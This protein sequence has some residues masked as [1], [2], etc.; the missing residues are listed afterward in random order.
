MG[1]P[2]E[3]NASIGAA[4][5]ALLASAEGE[6]MDF[7]SWNGVSDLLMMVGAR[8]GKEA[9]VDLVANTDTN[10]LLGSGAHRV[11][12]RVWEVRSR[13][14]DGEP[15]GVERG[16]DSSY[17]CDLSILT[18]IPGGLFVDAAEVTRFEEDLPQKSWIFGVP[19]IEGPSSTSFRAVAHTTGGWVLRSS[20]ENET[21]PSQVMSVSLPV[22][23]RYPVIVN[24]GHVARGA[25]APSNGLRLLEGVVLAN[26]TGGG[27]WWVQTVG[28]HEDQSEML[29]HEWII[30]SIH[31]EWAVFVRVVT[32]TLTSLGT[33]ILFNEGLR[34]T[35]LMQ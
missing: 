17:A 24:D 13:G 23:S 8:S 11:L 27:G 18:F 22:H 21:T 5:E 10:E 28:R 12:S 33:F 1:V 16:A 29:A 15:V 25:G 31:G 4:M 2:D 14:F 32:L 3:K 19:D 26:C 7:D 34:A 35:V 30:P 20:T 6:G 9:P